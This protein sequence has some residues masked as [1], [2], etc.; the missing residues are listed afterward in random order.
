VP[1]LHAMAAPTRPLIWVV[2]DEPVNRALVAAVVQRAGWTVREFGNAG[3]VTKALGQE[4]PAAVVL[5]IRM[6]GMSGDR[7]LP[8]LRDHFQGHAVRYVAYTAHYQPD[9]LSHLLGLGF[10]TVL[11]KPVSHKDIMSA[12]TD[13]GEPAS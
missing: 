10:D 2:D 6:P 5:D 4:V 12:L 1:E 8:V 7:L 3:E 11:L 13:Q 9:E